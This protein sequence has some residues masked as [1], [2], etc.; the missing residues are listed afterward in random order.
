M[1]EPDWA[2]M[3][4]GIGDVRR[5]GI[6]W[7]DGVATPYGIYDGRLGSGPLMGKKSER[8]DKLAVRVSYLSFGGFGIAINQKAPNT[9]QFAVFLP[10][11]S[12]GFIWGNFFYQL[13]AIFL[14]K[15]YLPFSNFL[16]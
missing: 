4:E 12:F 13:F 3:R 5:R 6:R 1:G 7:R 11:L 2:R 10:F 9:C 15:E 16:L 8:V 14:P